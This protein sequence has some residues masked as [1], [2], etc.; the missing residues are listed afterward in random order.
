V[1]ESVSRPR[2]GGLHRGDRKVDFCPRD[3]VECDAAIGIVCIAD[4]S[5]EFIELG[6]RGFIEQDLVFPD[7]EHVARIGRREREISHE[8]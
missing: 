8:P 2:P 6:E 3:R 5:D 4:S 7:F 1:L